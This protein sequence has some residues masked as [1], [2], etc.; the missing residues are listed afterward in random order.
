MAMDKKINLSKIVFPLSI[1]LGFIFSSCLDDFNRHGYYND[2]LAA[3]LGL[4]Q[5]NTSDQ[6][7]VINLDNGSV[8]TP[9]SILSGYIPKDSNRV[10]VRFSPL[11]ETHITDST[12]NYVSKIY[13]INDI[14]FKDVK[15]LSLVSEDSVGHDPIIVKGA[16]ISPKDILNIDFKIFRESSVHYI[17]LLDNG[18][19]DGVTNPYI[20]E[21]RHNARGDMNLYP[22]TGTVSF[23]LNSLRVQGQNQVQ[24]FIRYTDYNGNRIDIPKTYYY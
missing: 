11:S 17:N 10:L 5:T 12:F 3:S 18:D 19:G 24:F 8:V 23:K 13:D 1:I 22:I 2:N 20:L 9:S 21:F 15:K 16:W 4:V 14:L 6:S 7:F